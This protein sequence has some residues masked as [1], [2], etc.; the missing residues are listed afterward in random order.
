MFGNDA[1][2]VDVLNVLFFL[3][4]TNHYRQLIYAA[5]HYRHAANHY[6]QCIHAANHYRQCIH[7]ANHYRQFIHVANHYRQVIHAGFRF[8]T[9]AGNVNYKI[10]S[11][12]NQYVIQKNTNSKFKALTFVFYN[13]LIL[14]YKTLSFCLPNLI[15]WETAFYNNLSQLGW[16]KWRFVVSIF[17]TIRL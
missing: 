5:N 8:S 10:K 9:Q 17:I 1:R 2:R 16:Y 11:M 3:S 14:W 12:I 6:R 4:T 15:L 13:H 7:A